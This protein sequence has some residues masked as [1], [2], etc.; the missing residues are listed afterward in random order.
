MYE[1]KLDYNASFFTELDRPVALLQAMIRENR[2]ARIGQSTVVSRKMHTVEAA[3]PETVTVLTNVDAGRVFYNRQNGDEV[4]HLDIFHQCGRVDHRQV[5]ARLRKAV[6]IYGFHYNIYA[7]H[8]FG[9]R[10]VG[11]AVSADFVDV[12]TGT[13][14]GRITGSLNYGQKLSLRRAHENH[15]HVTAMLPGEHIAGLFYLV[16]AAEEAIRTAGLELRRNERI[17]HGRGGG[18]GGDLSP[19]CDQTDSFLRQKGCGATETAQRHQYLQDVT[20]LADEFDTVQDVRDVLAEADGGAGEQKLLQSLARRGSGEQ[21]L[22]RLERQGILAVEGGKVRMTE[23]GQGLKIYLDRHLPEIEAFLRRAFRLFRPPVWRPGRSKLLAEG[24]GGVG[25]R[26]LKPRD[27]SGPGGELAVAETVNAAARRTLDSARGGLEI[28]ADDL[29]E[30]VRKRRQ[31]AEICL[32]VDASASMT[33][34]RL[35]AAKFL[36]RHLLLSTPD[37]LAIIAFQEDSAKLVQPLTRDWQQVESSLRG[38]TS[39]GSTPLAGALTTCLTYLREANVRNPLIILITDG[40]PTVAEH[41]RDPLN[42]ALEAAASI[43]LSGYGFACIGLKPHRSFLAQLA[44]RAGGS[45]YVMEELEKHAMVNA[46]WSER[47][48]RCL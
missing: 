1:T 42:D 7:S 8:H 12:Q 3:R 18:G 43:K 25:P 38:I 24:Q 35:R 28:I 27:G 21:A 5:A 37:R 46:A 40:I 48:G 6:E 19:Y 34:Q 39:C 33:G 14:G 16:M 45:L 44:V 11:E 22:R 9:F 17:I 29:R 30:F 31:K 36:A 32:L 41:S 26:Q 4:F 23:Y 13:G 15:V 47:V 10:S 2:G 20:D